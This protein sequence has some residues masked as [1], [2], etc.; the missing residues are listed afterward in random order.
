MMANSYGKIK[1]VGIQ[2]EDIYA[3]QAFKNQKNMSAEAKKQ[4]A[5]RENQALIDEI[6]YFTVSSGFHQ[7]EISCMDICI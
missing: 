4:A 1:C 3:D 6:R 5:K 7:G 2:E